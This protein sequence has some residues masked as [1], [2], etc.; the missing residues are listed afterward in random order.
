MSRRQ[1]IA[2]W[3]P[4]S[5]TLSI[6]PRLIQLTLVTSPNIKHVYLGNFEILNLDRFERFLYVHNNQ[7]MF[8]GFPYANC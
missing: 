8:S 6:E 3:N 1:E 7:I 2:P 5:V 4:K